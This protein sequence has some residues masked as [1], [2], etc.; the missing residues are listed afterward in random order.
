MTELVNEVKEVRLGISELTIM[1]NLL[2]KTRNTSLAYTKLEEGFMFL[3]K[4]LE[5]L[6][7]ESPYPTEKDKAAKKIADSIDPN[8][9]SLPK[10]SDLEVVKQVRDYIQV[11]ISHGVWNRVFD[12]TTSGSHV[13]YSNIGWMFANQALMNIVAAKMWL[14]MEINSIV[15][16]SPSLDGERKTVEIHKADN[17]ADVNGADIAK[18][19]S[20]DRNLAEGNSE[21]PKQTGTKAK[22]TKK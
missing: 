10:G 14:G 1:V 9:V 7:N 6:G 20:D 21:K 3:G 12:I 18:G 2:E 8:K 13:G 19:T 15:N 22:P 4:I 11:I 17:V 16:A 5:Y